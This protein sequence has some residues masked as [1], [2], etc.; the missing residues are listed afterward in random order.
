[1]ARAKKRL[2]D[3]STDAAPVVNNY[4]VLVSPIITEKSAL[5]GGS[6]NV[7]VF[8][9]APKATKTEIKAAIERVFKV[10]VV[11]VRTCNFIGKR[12]RTARGQGYRSGYRKAYV[13]LKEGQTVDVVEGL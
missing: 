3:R 8:E 12:K 1:M 4:G 2:L 11:G 13:T 9:V 10:N 7:L 5:V 6:G